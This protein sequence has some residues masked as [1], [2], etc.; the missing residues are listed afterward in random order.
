MKVE[1]GV[2]RQQLLRR[3]VRGLTRGRRVRSLQRDVPVPGPDIL[4]TVLAVFLSR[5]LRLRQHRRGHEVGRKPW[6]RSAW[7][8]V[9]ARVN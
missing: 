3:T 6:T 1:A 5:G 7:V 9:R 8:R 4:Q 2:E